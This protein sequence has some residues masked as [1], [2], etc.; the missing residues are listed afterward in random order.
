[1]TFKTQCSRCGEPI[2]I[3][4]LLQQSFDN[5]AHIERRIV[6]NDCTAEFVES[7]VTRAEE[8]ENCAV[9]S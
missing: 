6:C 2:E 4:V 9:K 5:L 1:M 8:R 3:E 7:L